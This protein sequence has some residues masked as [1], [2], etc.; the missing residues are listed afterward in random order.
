MRSGVRHCAG[1]AVPGRPRGWLDVAGVGRTHR[2]GL[3][4]LAGSGRGAAFR[5]VLR[6]L[7]AGRRY[8]FVVERAICLTVLH[9]R[10]ASGSDRATEPWRENHLIPRTETLELYQLYR[11]TPFLG[12]QEEAEPPGQK[13]QPRASAPLL[14]V[15]QDVESNTPICSSK[16]E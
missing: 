11:A 14:E 10:F 2:A 1:V 4:C 16:V 13:S 9:R 6:A 12:E 8:G 15:A 7:L 5:E 3:G